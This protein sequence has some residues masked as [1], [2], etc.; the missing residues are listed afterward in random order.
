MKTKYKF[1]SIALVVGAIVG[2]TA[3][4]KT[5]VLDELTTTKLKLD[6]SQLQTL[7]AQA[8]PIIAD[9]NE[10]QEKAKKDFPGYQIDLNTMKLVVVTS[11]GK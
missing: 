3:Q 10:K 1:I 7:Q 6:Q 5:P 2:C 8:N 9:I 11:G 4:K